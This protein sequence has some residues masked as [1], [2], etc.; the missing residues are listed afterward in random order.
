MNEIPEN[1]KTTNTQSNPFYN[2]IAGSYNAML[3]NEPSNQV[4]RQAVAERFRGIV[5]AGWVLDFG[6]GTGLDLAWLTN[7]GYH[8]IFCEPSTKMREKAIQYTSIELRNDIIFLDEG[9]TD[10]SSWHKKLP[11]EQKVEGVLSNFAVINCIP[12]IELL[13]KNIAEVIKP[14]G[15]FIALILYYDLKKNLKAHS[16]NALKSFLSGK[17]FV[18]NVRFNQHHH[19]VF[20]YSMGQIRKACLPFF[21]IHG[22]EQLTGSEF[23]LIHLTRK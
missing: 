21:N 5:P 20:I 7:A 14:G 18:K 9:N 6:G 3:D 15:H 19:Q 11:F 16:R 23:S 17:P 12:D 13:F 10:Y 1:S 8:V 4:V 2:E 22:S